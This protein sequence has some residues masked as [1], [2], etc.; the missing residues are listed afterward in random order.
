MQ[1]LPVSAFVLQVQNP[2][3]IGHAVSQTDTLTGKYTPVSGSL[4]PGGTPAATYS[5]TRLY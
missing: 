4:I 3:G 2:P 5:A 1:S